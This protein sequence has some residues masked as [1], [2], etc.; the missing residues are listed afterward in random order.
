MSIQ[1][2]SQILQETTTTESFVAQMHLPLRWLEVLF[3]T[4]RP[5]ELSHRVLMLFVTREWCSMI[6]VIILH[7]QPLMFV[8]KVIWNT[9]P[10]ANYLLLAA[11]H[12]SVLLGC[13]RAFVP[14]RP[15]V[16]RKEE[17]KGSLRTLLC[18]MDTWLGNHF[19]F[20]LIVCDWKHSWLAT[21]KHNFRS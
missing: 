16:K 7:F 14:P 12:C 8:L 17:G 19:Q 3:S 2:R 10:L 1:S 11:M 6:Y 9:L 15:Q 20:L 13:A 5:I 18:A 4:W 21:L